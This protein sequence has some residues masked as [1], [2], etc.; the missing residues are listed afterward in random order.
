MDNEINIRISI[1]NRDYLAMNKIFKSR[2]LLKESKVKNYTTYLRP[3][4]AIYG[5]ETWSTIKNDEEKLL[6][7]E[8]KVLR[9]IY[10]SKSARSRRIRKK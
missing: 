2:L 4:V 5:Y 3:A 9:R 7:F 6:R 10:G 1:A 8:R